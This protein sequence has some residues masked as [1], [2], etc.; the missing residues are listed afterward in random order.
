LNPKD[1]ALVASRIGN[2]QYGSVAGKMQMGS[3]WW[4]LDTM[5]GMERQMEDL[6]NLGL[7]SRFVGMLTDSR[8]FTSYTRHEYF[9]RILCNVF[10]R[11]IERGLIPRD[12][13]LVGGIVRGIC[14]ENAASFFGFGDTN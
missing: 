10:G 11:D 6:S 5:D 3:G 7:I 1:N 9:R 13:E 14:H 2:F 12:F 8:S 4:F